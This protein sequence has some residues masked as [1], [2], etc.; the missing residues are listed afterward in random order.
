MCSWRRQTRICRCGKRRGTARGGALG[1]LC[2]WMACSSLPCPRGGCMHCCCLYRELHFRGSMPPALQTNARGRG[3]CFTPAH[4]YPVR[5]AGPAQAGTC[6]RQEASARGRGPGWAQAL[7]A[8]V[9]AC[10]CSAHHAVKAPLAA[11]VVDVGRLGVALPPLGPAEGGQ[12]GQ[13][14]A[15]HVALQR[16]VL[17]RPARACPALC[18]PLVCAPERMGVGVRGGVGEGLPVGRPQ[19]FT[20][21]C[22]A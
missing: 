1:W 6:R 20:C 11:V 10:C 12:T 7:R 15:T 9:P 17:Y 16:A 18:A 13:R 4:R 3:W 14:S 21:M 5:C 19:S 8:C 22:T 2:A